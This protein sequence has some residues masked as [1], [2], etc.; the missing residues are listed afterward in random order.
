MESILF[1][2]FEFIKFFKL[3]HIKLNQ[4]LKEK[5]QTN[6]TKKKNSTLVISFNNFDLLDK[7][8]NISW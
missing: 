4:E 8:K 3:F 2:Q 1:W 7:G 6:L 5:I